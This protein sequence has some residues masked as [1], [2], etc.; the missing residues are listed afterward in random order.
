MYFYFKI[1]NLSS[2][3]DLF[4][5]DGSKNEETAGLTCDG[6]FIDMSHIAT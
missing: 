4:I 6:F 5:F 1:I 3:D 2:S